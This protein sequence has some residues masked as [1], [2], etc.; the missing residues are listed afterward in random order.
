MPDIGL[1]KWLN[2]KPETSRWRGFVLG[3]FWRKRRDSNPRGLA[4]KWFS[5]PPRYDHFDTLPDWLL[6]FLK[7]IFCRFFCGIL[8]FGCCR[9]EFFDRILLAD[10][11][12]RAV[13]SSTQIRR[14]GEVF[15]W[16]GEGCRLILKDCPFDINFLSRPPRYDRFDTL[17]FYEDILLTGISVIY[18]W[19]AGNR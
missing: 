5:R 13:C 17:P 14:F 1:Q 10:L 6:S 11:L 16:S 9:V 3:L 2:N 7:K 12:L 8:R 19:R 15:S 18:G 4:P